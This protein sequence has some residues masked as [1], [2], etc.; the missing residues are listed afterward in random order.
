[1]EITNTRVEKNW[2]RVFKFEVGPI[3]VSKKLY[4]PTIKRFEKWLNIIEKEEYFNKFDFLLTGSF[5]N[6]INNTLPWKT[7]DIDIILIDNGNNSLELIRDTLIDLSRVALEQCD[8]YMD[9]YYQNKENVELNKVCY[10]GGIKNCKPYSFEKVGLTYAPNVKRDDVIV[11]NWNIDEEV[12][13]G[14]W[15]TRLQ[16]PSDKQI[17][18]INTGFKYDDEIYLS[19]YKKHFTLIETVDK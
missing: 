9:V 19:E 8:F 17:K 18:R 2:G 7:W 5:P 3:K 4:M 1:M 14:L 13:K 11:S 6:Y 16:F 15:V 12:I 10:R